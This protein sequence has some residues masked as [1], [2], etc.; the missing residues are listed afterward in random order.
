MI[1]RGCIKCKKTFEYKGEMGVDRGSMTRKICD[2]CKL[3]QHRNE[4]KIY[5]LKYSKKNREEIRR[6]ARLK[7][8][9][10]NPPHLLARLVRRK[11]EYLNNTVI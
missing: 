1:T 5:S 10:K 8:R 3:L 9:S 11:Y 2:Q 7:Y 4:S 6:K